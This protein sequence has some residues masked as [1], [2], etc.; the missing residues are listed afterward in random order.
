MKIHEYQAKQVLRSA[1]VAVLE[2]HV[3]ETPDE[4]AKAFE[5]LGGKV[6]VV[7]A[8]IHAG[9]RGKGTTKENPAQHG[10]QLVKS[11]DEARQVAEGLLGKT[12]VT[13]QTG[14][15]GKTVNKVFVEAGC[16][17]ARELYLGI[18]LDRAAAMPVL[19]V[20]T[21]G[22]MEIE[23]V[24][25][26][27]PERIFKEHFDPH[28]G[29]QS[30]QVRKL[31]A[32]LGIKGKSV[33]SADKFMRALCEVYV[34]YDCSLAEI[35]PLVVTGEGELVALDA[36]M[37]FDSNAMFR[38]KDIVEFR[39]L[40]EEEPLEVRAAEAGLSY[41]KL[42]GNI[43]CLVNGAG[44]AMST[45]D[46]IKLNGGQ[47]AN[48]LDV[49]GGANAEQVT[50][51]FRIILSDPHVKAVLVNIFGGIMRCTTIAEALVQAYKTVGFN[52]PLVVRLEG[53]EVQEGK[54]IIA[55]SDVDIITADDIN[56]A[57]RKVVATLA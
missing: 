5:T 11:A 25:E 22:G 40:T 16:N 34:K 26:E 31:C 6:A 57:A 53:T 24:A 18:V 15:E 9:G 29:L 55:E 51:A 27:T 56:D 39:D 14:S 45:M 36:K 17:I 32:K 20:S 37:S 46:I 52:V 23:K 43:G 30:Y 2:G 28:F 3:A 41:I 49:G 21:E 35:N 42:E 54:K 38:H 47:P 48:F 19:M 10:V 7:K 12:L 13:I 50:E 1:G 8:Q 33:R 4:A 44:L